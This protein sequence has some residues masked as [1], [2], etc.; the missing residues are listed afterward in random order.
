MEGVRFEGGKGRKGGG[1]G[2][3]RRKARVG[4]VMG[5]GG[6]LRMFDAL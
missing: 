5:N 6:I 4:G 3:G 1:I 2:W